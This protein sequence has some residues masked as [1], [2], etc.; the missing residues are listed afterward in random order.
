MGHACDAVLS[1][2]SIGS[3]KWPEQDEGT[4]GG[5]PESDDEANDD[6]AVGIDPYD[7]PFTYVSLGLCLLVI[8]LF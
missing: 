3:V 8:L 1:N 4:W 7:Y 6:M 2:F 5:G